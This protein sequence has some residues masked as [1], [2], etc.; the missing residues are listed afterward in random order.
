MVRKVLYG[1]LKE[2]VIRMDDEGLQT[3]LCE[4]ESILNDRP[5]STTSDN[6][7][8][9]DVITPSHLLTLRTTQKFPPGI[10]NK[11]D[12]YSRRRW[13]Q[14]QYLADIFWCRWRREY[15]TLLQDRQK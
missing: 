8:D 15:L 12:N 14:V 3:L 2:Q 6:P 1:V 5:I 7:D 4:V 9:L 10:F 11:N 13:R